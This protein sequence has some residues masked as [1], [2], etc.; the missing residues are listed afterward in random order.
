MTQPPPALAPMAQFTPEYW[1]KAPRV[2]ARNKLVRITNMPLV[3]GDYE[4]VEFVFADNQAFQRRRE[5]LNPNVNLHVNMDAYVETINGELVTG[6]WIPEQ[7]WAFR[8]TSED[9][10]EY[11]KRLSAAMHNQRQRAEQQV[12][13]LAA[14]V[15]ANAIYDQCG[16]G[17]REWMEAIDFKQVAATLVSALRQAKPNS[18]PNA[19]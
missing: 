19:R 3:E 14:E 8:M 7:G 9:L 6:M 2:K 12:T 10:A 15:I 4:Y 5:D 1:D 17:G 18:T 13:D 16:E 11:A